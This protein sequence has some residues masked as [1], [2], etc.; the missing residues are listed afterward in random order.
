[1]AMRYAD[2]RKVFSPLILLAG[3]AA[4]W[5]APAAAAQRV[6][7]PENYGARHDGT[8]LDT[9]AI[10]HALDTCG[11][12]GTVQLGSG[13]YLS[14]PLVLKSGATL[15]VAKGAILRATTDKAAYQHGDGMLALINASNAHDLTLQ[16]KGVIDGQGASWW[17]EVKR[18]KAAGEQEAPRPRLILLNHVNRVTVQDLTLQNSPSFHLVPADA[19]HV[20]ID[21]VTIRAPAD[22]PNTDGIDPSG[23]FMLIRNT[24]IDVGD[25]NIAIKSGHSDPQ[26]PASATANITIR[27]CTFLNGHGLS[28][29]SET[30]GGVQNILAERIQFDGTTTALRIKTDRD[31]GGEISHVTYRD[32]RIAHVR[33]AIDITSYYPKI[34]ADDTPRPLAAMTPN[35]HD[36]LFDN[37]TGHE[38][39]GDLGTMVGLPERPLRNIKMKRVDLSAA[40]GLTV[41]NAQL[42]TDTTQLKVANGT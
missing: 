16:G 19:S 7:L 13:V 40:K 27:D 38:G 39:I 22:A 17:A 20:L 15:E 8:T 34:P 35:I 41:R 29:G 23:R 2:G 6:C 30:N 36:I 1:M 31:R 5:T 32:I 37:V 12:H 28:I 9:Q 42:K 11:S 14:G 18:A 24:T 3:L 26:Y 4:F 10:Q 33:E 21:G 25:D